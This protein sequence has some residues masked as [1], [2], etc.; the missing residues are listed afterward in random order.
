MTKKKFW[1]VIP[2]ILL[3]Y[4]ALF[5]LATVFLSTKIDFFRYI[6]EYVFGSN[7]LYLIGNFIL[8][9][10]LTTILNIIC[11][12]FSIYNKWDALSLVK[13]MMIIKLIQIPAYVLIFVLGIILAITIFTFPFSIGLFLFDCLSLFLTGALVVSAAINSIKQGFFKLKDILWIMILQ[14]FFCVDVI[15]TIIF[16]VKLKNIADNSSIQNVTFSNAWIQCNY[17]VSKLQSL[18]KNRQ[19]SSEACRFLLK[20]VKISGQIEKLIF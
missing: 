8:C 14:F 5:T 18:A 19:V 11:F 1:I 16:Y 7:S 6:M 12:A 2:T 17:F 15:S 13:T 20:V 9:C 4:L 3:P 10:I